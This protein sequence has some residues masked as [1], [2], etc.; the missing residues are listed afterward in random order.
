MKKFLFK[1]FIILLILLV[2]AAAFVFLIGYGYYSNVLHEKS[3]TQRVDS[4]TNKE[5]YV[6]YDNLSKKFGTANGKFSDS[7]Q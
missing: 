1:L 6:G 3:L 7:I 2:L 5:H 4:V